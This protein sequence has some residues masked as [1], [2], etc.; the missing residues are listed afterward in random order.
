M[1]KKYSKLNI[2]NKWYSKMITF[3]SFAE[4]NEQENY[5]WTWRENLFDRHTRRQIN[6]PLL[7]EFNK[8]NPKTKRSKKALKINYFNLIKAINFWKIN[9][10]SKWIK[11]NIQELKVYRCEYY[12]PKCDEIQFRPCIF[13]KLNSFSK[14]VMIFYFSKVDKITNKKYGVIINELSS[15]TNLFQYFIPTWTKIENIENLTIIDFHNKDKNIFIKK[16]TFYKMLCSLY[17]SLQIDHIKNGQLKDLKKV[18][19]IIRNWKKQYKS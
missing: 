2:R 6:V 1:T 12:N 11:H 10:E 18:N 15:K 3:L 5:W 7:E 14:E 9:Y 17:N 8:I 19:S 16:D 13:K 4:Y